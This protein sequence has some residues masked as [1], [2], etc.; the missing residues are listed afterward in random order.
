MQ[1]AIDSYDD[2][3]IEANDDSPQAPVL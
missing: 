3:M 1:R 2:V